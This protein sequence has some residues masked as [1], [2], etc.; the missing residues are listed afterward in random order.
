VVPH[1]ASLADINAL[2]QLV[3]GQA[4]R[5]QRRASFREISTSS[6]FGAAEDE[7]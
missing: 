1:A 2:K 4:Y 5:N 6:F 3:F 7:V